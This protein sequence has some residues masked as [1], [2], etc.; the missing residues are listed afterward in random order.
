MRP[1]SADA[2]QPWIASRA[3]R[4]PARFERFLYVFMMWGVFIDLSYLCGVFHIE[5]ET[6]PCG[7][8]LSYGVYPYLELL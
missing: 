8:P 6:I 2:R 4:V 1:T 5:V 7:T 3:L